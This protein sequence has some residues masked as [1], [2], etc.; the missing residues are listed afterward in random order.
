MQG[1]V[2]AFF[3]D[4]RRTAGPHPRR[5]A[6]A[7]RLHGH[8]DDG[9]LDGRRWA[10]VGGREE[11]CAPPL[12]A[13]AAPLALLA[14]PRRAMSYNIRVLTVRAVADLAYPDA[15]RSSWRFS[16]AHL[17]LKGSSSTP[18][19]HLQPLHQYVPLDWASSLPYGA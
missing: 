17:L 1:P 10:S 12:W 4:R 8:L 5:I 6:A 2:F 13:R 16:A 3:A 18:L 9:L 7:A 14:W 19:K 15:T 11:Q